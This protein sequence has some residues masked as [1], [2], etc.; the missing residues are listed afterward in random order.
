M[1]VIDAC[2]K[3]K[4]YST[5]RN[6]IVRN[7]YYMCILIAYR[8]KLTFT[9]LLLIPSHSVTN[10]C[11]GNRNF[12]LFRVI[13]KFYRVMTRSWSLAPAIMDGVMKLLNEITKICKYLWLV[14]FL[15]KF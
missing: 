12:K 3:F 2:H 14:Q 1:A 5:H 10:N 6:D 4:Q 8:L 7:T 11:N 13:L 15:T 9:V